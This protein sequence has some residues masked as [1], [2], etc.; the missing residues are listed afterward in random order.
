[1]PFGFY[2][3]DPCKWP[4]QTVIVEGI[5]LEIDPNT[6]LS[7][8]VVNDTP[9]EVTTNVEVE[10][11]AS[12]DVNII[13]ECLPT[14]IKNTAE[15]P[16]IVELIPCK[17]GEQTSVYYT[18]NEDR[19]VPAGAIYG[20]IRHIDDRG[21]L[22]E[23]IKICDKNGQLIRELCFGDTFDLLESDDCT[24]NTKDFGAEYV[25][26]AQGNAYIADFKYPSSAAVPNGT[27]TT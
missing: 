11:P 19:T 20:E 24:T 26:K 17:K 15:N 10:F 3:F 7:V 4:K 22:P 8:E 18:G 5:S 25:I 6:P 14:E 16:V 23:K 27:L 21:E 2:V 9:I 1:M 12:L 13:N